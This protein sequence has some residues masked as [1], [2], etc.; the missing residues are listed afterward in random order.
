M[1]NLDILPAD[2]AN[3]CLVGRVWRPELEGPSIVTIRDGAVFDICHAVPTMRDLCEA[4]DPAGLVSSADGCFI[5]KL[6]EIAARSIEEIGR[7]HHDMETG[8]GSFGNRVALIGSLE[9]GHGRR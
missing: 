4:E 3:A 9:P 5:G 8:V 7:A 2:A 6:E 1:P